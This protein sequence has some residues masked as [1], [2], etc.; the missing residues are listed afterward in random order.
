VVAS[1]V[2]T[3]AIL[4][5][6]QD[7]A[8]QRHA[9]LMRFIVINKSHT[10]ARWADMLYAADSGYW[11]TSESA[12][13]FRGLQVAP[14]V[15]CQKH[16]PRV[17]VVPI[18]TVC[19]KRVDQINFTHHRIGGGGFSGFQALNVAIKT[20]SREIYLAGFDFHD[21]HWHADHTGILRNPDRA[22]LTKWRDLLDSQYDLI[23]SHGIQVYN[24]SDQSQLKNYPHKNCKSVCE[25]FTT[26]QTSVV[27]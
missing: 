13:A 20:G 12:R 7:C 27:C 5:V 23:K 1:G 10:L 2:S 22:Q 16:A 11:A 4:G 21:H 18:H 26:L 19:G 25:K 24:L 6:L 15:Q 14:D 17:L 8:R 9:G 3:P